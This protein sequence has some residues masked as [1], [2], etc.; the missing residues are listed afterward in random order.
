MA[1]R[2][3][4][5]VR[6]PSPQEAVGPKPAAA[7]QDPAV[8]TEA[9]GAGTRPSEA[10]LPAA[11]GRGPEPRPRPIGAGELTSAAAALI[12]LALMFGAKWYGVAGVPD[13]SAARPAVSTAID[14]WNALAIVRWVILLTVLVAVGSLLLHLSQRSHGS[15]TDTSRLVTALGALTS[16]LLIYRVLFALP[17]A[18]QV[19]DQKLGA[20]L[21]LACA[22]T[23]ALGGW[24]SV[25]EQKSPGAPAAPRL[26]R[27]TAGSR[28]RDR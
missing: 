20:L 6:G 26:R 14:G 24:Q 5:G 13:P 18:E 7:A 10:S 12:L 27:Q 11:G 25:L 28:R 4:D 19:I 21:G 16:A 1:I 9:L 3:G 15:R 2:T 22:L 17:S 23:I 8:G